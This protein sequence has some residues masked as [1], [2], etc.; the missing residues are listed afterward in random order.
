MT[1]RCF[2]V[3]ELGEILQ[4]NAAD[5]RRLHI[6][7]CPR[8]QSRLLVYREFVEDSTVPEGA[9]LQDAAARLGRAFQGEVAP[10]RSAR[11]PKSRSTLS[12]LMD[13]LWAPA[14]KPAWVGAGVLVMAFVA[15]TGYQ[16]YWNSKAP[17]VLR[18]AGPGGSMRSGS[19]VLRPA[20]VGPDGTITL[21]WGSVTG[22]DTYRVRLLSSALADLATF[23][24]LP[25]TSL[26]V[27]AEHLPRG[28]PAGTL[29]GWQVEALASGEVLA[30][31]P[32]GTLPLP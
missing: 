26:A 27:A 4:L 13:S 5:P 16:A 17:D 15:Y 11:L 28:L 23:G 6:D 32:T 25:D 14:L 22:A 1:D 7:A 24:P 9:R 10:P 18:G 3:E 19:V 29:V 8:C 20:R 21:S 2:E 12:R 31:S 30:T